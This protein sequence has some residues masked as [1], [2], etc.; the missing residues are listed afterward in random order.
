MDR[1][2]RRFCN[3]ERIGVPFFGGRGGRLRESA[4][5]LSSW[6]AWGCWTAAVNKLTGNKFRKRRILPKKKKKKKLTPPENSGHA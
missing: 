1:S 2:K 5:A 3:P 4:R 6:F